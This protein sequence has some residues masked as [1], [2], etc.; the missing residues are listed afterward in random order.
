[1]AN[2]ELTQLQAEAAAMRDELVTVRRDLHAHPELAFEEVRTAGIVATTLN[3]L[4]YEVQTGVGK[5]GVVGL[6]EGGMPGPE[7]LLLRFDMDALP[8]HEAVDVEFR[9]PRAP[10]AG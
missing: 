10:G 6:M 2:F 3:A 7:T 9:G 4:G 1:M 5:T 8:I